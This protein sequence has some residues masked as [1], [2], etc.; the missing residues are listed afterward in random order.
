MKMERTAR[1]PVILIEYLLESLEKRK[2]PLHFSSELCE[3]LAGFGLVWG[4][5]SAD[6]ISLLSIVFSS[7]LPESS[8]DVWPRPQE[9][10]VSAKSCLSLEEARLSSG[11]C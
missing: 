3:I 7:S 8:Q 2:K 4:F 9:D 10:R 1:S 5:I 11:V 6:G